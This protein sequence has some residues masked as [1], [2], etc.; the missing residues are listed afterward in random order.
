MLRHFVLLLITV[1]QSI[2]ASQDY[3]PPVVSTNSFEDIQQKIEKYVNKFGA[4]NVLV[5]FDVNQTLMRPQNKAAWPQARK[6]FKKAWE[7]IVNPLS[8]EHQ[9]IFFN[10][11][12][13]L[14]PQEIIHKDSVTLVNDLQKRGVVTL[15]ITSQSLG[16]VPGGKNGEMYTFETL[17]SMG[18]DFSKSFKEL[19]D[20]LAFGDF[21]SIHGLQAGYYKGIVFAGNNFRLSRKGKGLLYFLKKINFYPKAIIYV[22]N[23]RDSVAEVH[24][25]LKEYMPEIKLKA[26]EFIGDADEDITL[27][28]EEFVGFWNEVLKSLPN[29]NYGVR[30]TGKLVPQEVQSYCIRV[31]TLNKMGWMHPIVDPITAE[32]LELSKSERRPMLEIGAAFGYAS[33]IALENGAN[34]WV[35]DLEARHL[36]H[37][38]SNLEPD[39]LGRANFVAGH[40]PIDF[41]GIT[42]KFAAILAVRVFHFYKPAEFQEAILKLFEIL[43]PGGRV[44]IVVESPYLKTWAMHVPEYE[45]RKSAGDPFPGL[46]DNVYQ[47]HPDLK[48]YA[49]PTILFLDAETLVREFSKVGFKILKSGFLNRRDYPRR[50]RLD[51]RECAYIV[52]EKPE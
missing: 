33:K 18:I 41:Q 35:N 51:G 24:R 48:D 15:G 20:N 43:V 50:I 36:E 4:E 1:I 21:G 22:D 26:Y 28:E 32:F 11:R 23:H 5:V 6:K 31:P 25:E 45:A 16:K 46:I 27:E 19:D 10:L 7:K 9:I 3:F 49:Q 8:G 12:G 14:G 13:R 40:F 39:E 37:L 29:H 47:V 38:K 30:E 17:K 42:G 2:V 34:L 52:A 44:Y